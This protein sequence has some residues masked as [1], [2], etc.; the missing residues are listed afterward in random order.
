MRSP[1]EAWEREKPKLPPSGDSL[2]PFRLD[3]FRDEGYRGPA[4]LLQNSG[5]HNPESDSDVGKRVGDVTI[6][7]SS[8]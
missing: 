2:M 7:N 6:G 5:A 1:A 3:A 8:V 4:M